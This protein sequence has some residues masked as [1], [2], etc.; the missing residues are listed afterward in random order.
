M[1]KTT[2]SQSRQ[3]IEALKQNKET[4]RGICNE[5]FETFAVNLETFRIVPE[6]GKEDAYVNST[7]FG[8]TAIG[9]RFQFLKED[10]NE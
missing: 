1:K 3:A 2:T 6:E 7:R 4:A 8:N 9:F 5:Y 10:K